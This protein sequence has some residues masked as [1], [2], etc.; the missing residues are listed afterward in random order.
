M[1]SVAGNYRYF[2][3][4]YGTPITQLL[5]DNHFCLINDIIREENLPDCADYLAARPAPSDD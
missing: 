3:A 1:D 2:A 5:I 4:K